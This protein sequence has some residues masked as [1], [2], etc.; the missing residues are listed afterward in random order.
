MDVW[1]DF[2]EQVSIFREVF[3]STITI[4]NPIAKIGDVIRGSLL[5]DRPEQIPLL[6]KSVTERVTAQ[7]GK[8]YIKNFWDDPKP[9][10]L[11]YVGVHI[12]MRMPIPSKEINAA[13][14]RNQTGLDQSG[15]KIH[16][17]GTSTP[18]QR[19]HGWDERLCKGNRAPS[20]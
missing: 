5:A 20:L 17:H 11:G 13:R 1:Q 16:P 19:D 7:G 18:Y 15:K 2:N 9:L 3:M 10:S 12:K 14:G 6:L 8:F 4:A